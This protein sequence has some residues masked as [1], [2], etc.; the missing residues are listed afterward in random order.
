[1]VLLSNRLVVGYPEFN[2]LGL[3]RL[4]GDLKLAET[5]GGGWREE[6]DV[7]GDPGLGTNA[8]GDLLRLIGGGGADNVGMGGGGG[9]S[10]ENCSSDCCCSVS[11]S[12][13]SNKLTDE[14]MFLDSRCSVKEKGTETVTS[15]LGCSKSKSSRR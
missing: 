11:F 13:N 5:G 8:A 2:V 9:S 1:V 4:L 7:A 15:S 12:W 6:D 10:G 3:M 14:E